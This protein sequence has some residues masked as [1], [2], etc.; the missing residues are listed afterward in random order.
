MRFRLYYVYKIWDELIREL[1]SI[2]QPYVLSGHQIE[3]LK[4]FQFG[5]VHHQ[6]GLVHNVPTSPVPYQCEGTILVDGVESLVY[7]ELN[8]S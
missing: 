2:R 3:F 5:R 6:F 7:V 8:P 1:A 4:F